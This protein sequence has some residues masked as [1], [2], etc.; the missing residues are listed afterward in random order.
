MEVRVDLEDLQ[1]YETISVEK[2]AEGILHVRINRPKRLNA[3]SMKFFADLLDFFTRVNGLDDLRAIILT[4]TGTHFSSG[5]DL[6]DALSLISFEEGKDGARNSIDMSKKI[7]FLQ[8]SISSVERCRVPVIAGV[9]GFCLG[10]A[11]DLIMACDIVY[12]SKGTR[13]SI[14]EVDVAMVA[15]LGTLQR[16]VL[17]AGSDSKVRELALTGRE[18]SAEEAQT[19]GIVNQVFNDKT[20]LEAAL[21][22]TAQTIAEKTPIAI[23]GIKKVLNF[24]NQTRIREGLDYV[25]ALNMSLLFT[26]DVKKAGLAALQKSKALYPKL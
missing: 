24:Q 25:Q 8:E 13:M 7:R 3:M 26:D 11:I 21:L 1:K 16:I 19:I 14:K 15:D 17:K 18:F 6:T 22:R 23:W 2:V 5:L 12:G 20:E 9:H 10:G 4:G